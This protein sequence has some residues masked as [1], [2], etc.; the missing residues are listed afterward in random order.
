M[1]SEKIKKHPGS[2]KKKSLR[3]GLVIIIFLI[4][5]RLILPYIIL[6]YA[7]KSLSNM[8]G[9]YGKIKDI[10]LALYRGAYKIKDLYLHKKDSVTNFETEFFDSQ[11]IDLAIDW[12]ALFDGKIV[13]EITVEEPILRFI[14]DKTEPK[15]IQKDSSDFKKVLDDFMPLQIN[16]FEINY[17]IIKYVDKNSTPKVDIEMNN[18]HVTAENLT[19]AKSLT[20]L[21]STV[22]ASADIYEGTLTL[23]MKLD[24]LAQNPTF[25]LNS[26]L[27]NTNL[28]K[29]NEFFKAYGKIDVSRGSFG[30]YTEVAGKEGKFVGYVKPIIKDLKVLGP[31]DKNDGL[32][33]KFWEGIV[34]GVGV[35]FR[36]QK[37]DQIATKIP[38]EGSFGKTKV[39]TWR[40]IMEI[41]RN[42][43]I[44][45]LTPS[46]D[47]EI[48]LSS[49]GNTT[50]KGIF[51]GNKNNRKE[52]SKEEK[53]VTKEDKKEENPK[54]EKKEKKGLFK[55]LFNKKNKDKKA[56][57]APAEE[58]K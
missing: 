43:F 23:D 39:Y 53:T 42:A 11:E 35:L 34:G 57:E 36:N 46:L 17:G 54:E 5:A 38:I 26:E 21:P 40:A 58:P 51:K 6:H 24:P 28:V 41:L 56:K 25:D 47:N 44:E 18:T 13:G 29:L 31:E 15:Q 30:L 10:D 4:I 19:N 3:I 55:K 32:L 2:S 22:T 49:V 50:E 1:N 20:S 52:K 7:N 37:E 9:Y 33:R 14:K 48:N 16:R 8:N 45:A 27:K 12:A